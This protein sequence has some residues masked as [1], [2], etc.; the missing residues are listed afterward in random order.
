MTPLVIILSAS[1][2]IT[3]R[4]FWVEHKKLSEKVATSLKWLAHIEL[5]LKEKGIWEVKF[6]KDN[7]CEK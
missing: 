6:E 7:D 4:V 3:L 1:L 2:L 5:V